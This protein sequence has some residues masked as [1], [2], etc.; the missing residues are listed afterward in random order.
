METLITA[1]IAAL[2]GILVGAVINALADDLPHRATPTAPHYPN[3]APRP[4]S[5]WIAIIAFLTGQREGGAVEKSEEEEQQLSLEEIA[6]LYFDTK[7]PW[8]HVIVEM[9]MAIVFAFIV[10]YWPDH[11]R[12]LI[13]MIFISIL[14]LITVI[15][16]EHR[17]IL[18]VVIIP[19][20]LI[21]L[22]LNGLFPEVDRPFSE[23]LWGGL[24]G[25][26]I[27]YFMFLGGGVFADVVSTMQG[28]MISEVAFGFGDVML[29]ILCGFMIGWRSM[30]FATF[31]AVFAGAIGATL[32]L[33]G[34]AVSR[35]GY[36]M[37]TALPY[38]PYIVFG[39]VVMMLFT[40]EIRE[41]LF[42]GL[43]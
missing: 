25:G 40:E 19:S 24:L 15:D 28:R 2:A 4:P 34:R 10:L 8:R 23:Y 9:T 17:L 29:A 42:D 32:Y 21:T 3:G 1:I 37:Y 36:S 11:P 18:F 22:I 13:W 7:L 39:V 20:V 38:G 30:I 5:A 16:L 35:R 33:L 31:I 27:F 26:G 41:A 43:F 6:N 14:M 12:T